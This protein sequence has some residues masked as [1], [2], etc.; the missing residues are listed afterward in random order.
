LTVQRTSI[1][2]SPAA[3]IRSISDNKGIRHLWSAKFEELPT[4][5]Q[6]T[7]GPVC[8]RNR[9]RAKSSSLMKITALSRTA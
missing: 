6:T 4:R 9:R 1:S 2:A 8:A 5:S 7:V 3:T